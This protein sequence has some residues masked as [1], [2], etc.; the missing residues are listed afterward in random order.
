MYRSMSLFAQ[1]AWEE[2]GFEAQ[3]LVRLVHR[4]ARAAPRRADRPLAQRVVER[5]HGE[6]GHLH[7]GQ[8]FQ[9]LLHGMRPGG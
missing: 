5:G 9:G 7:A 4:G 3:A 6:A 1:G 8:A 2:P